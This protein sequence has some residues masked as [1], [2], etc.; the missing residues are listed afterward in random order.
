MVFYS[1]V[2][3]LIFYLT[4]SHNSHVDLQYST[5]TSPFYCFYLFVL[6]S[7]GVMRAQVV[8]PLPNDVENAVT[9]RA[10]GTCSCLSADTRHPLAVP[11]TAETWSDS[12]ASEQTLR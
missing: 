5:D 9:I 10:S 11:D 7:H 1:S 6:V 12:T 8:H 2:H 3:D 4:V